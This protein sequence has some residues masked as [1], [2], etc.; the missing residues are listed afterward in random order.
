M[1]LETVGT[2]GWIRVADEQPPQ[3]H[4]VETCII[5]AK[6]IRNVQKLKRW[7]RL[8]FVPDGGMY[9]YYEPTHWR[10]KR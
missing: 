9:V 10:A 8:W 1:S 4:L 7:D 6:G 3:G 2:D 5:D